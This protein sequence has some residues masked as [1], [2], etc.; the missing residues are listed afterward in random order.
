MRTSKIDLEPVRTQTN[1]GLNEERAGTDLALHAAEAEAAEAEGGSEARE[2]RIPPA[3]PGMPDTRVRRAE[4]VAFLRE[5]EEELANERAET[6][7]RLRREREKTDEVVDG[8]GMLLLDERTAHARA[9][10][11]VVRRDQLLALV[12]HELRSPLTVITLNT[13]ALLLAPSADLSQPEARAVLHDIEASAAQMTSLIGDL[14]DVAGM[15]AGRLKVTLAHGDAL[16]VM[17]AAIAASAPMLKTRRLSLAVD[18]PAGQMF[19]RF[20]HSRLLQVF[21]NLFANA[22]K[23]TRPDGSLSLGV[24]RIGDT[25]QFCLRDTGCGMVPEDAAHVFERFWQVGKDDRRG[26]GLGLYLCKAIV[27]A[28]H[29]TMWVT[30]EAGVG[31]SFYF[32]V[33]EA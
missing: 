23:F 16:S 2:A 7:A 15:E 5:V 9:E 22:V 18:A 8:A 1:H 25:L 14:L 26:L 24:A 11:A 19:A 30:S 21:A 12:S 4:S 13:Q 31:S 32:T 28:H 10:T 3:K 33:P 6:D 29:G 17:H 27:E 20:D